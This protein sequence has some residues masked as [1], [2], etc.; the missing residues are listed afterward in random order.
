MTKT[1]TSKNDTWDA[2]VLPDGLWLALPLIPPSQ[3]Q[4]LR[5]HW[6]RRK[7]YLDQL[8]QD[9]AW[10]AAAR[11]CPRFRQAVVQIEYFF[12]DRR[13]RDKDNYNGKFL[14]DAL[15]R[16]GILEDD[17]ADLISLPEPEFNLDRHYPRTEI[18]ITDVL[19][20]CRERP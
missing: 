13:S 9:I 3:N 5:W 18:W 6:A 12:R 2:Y 17:R 1:I 8:G 15:R 20:S 11:R 16:A 19:P 4:Y 14:L 10:L 7:R